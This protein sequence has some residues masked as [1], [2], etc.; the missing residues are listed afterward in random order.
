MAVWLLRRRL[1]PLLSTV[2]KRDVWMA[3]R[4]L[5]VRPSVRPCR[6]HHGPFGASEASKLILVADSEGTLVA[7]QT[8]IALRKLPSP[9]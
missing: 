6:L 9:C 4:P 7:T 8:V 5:S 1:R 3:C 2:A